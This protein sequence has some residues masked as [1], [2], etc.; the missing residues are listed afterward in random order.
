[1]AGYL[2]L[3]MVAGYYAALQFSAPSDA[4]REEASAPS[5]ITA[6]TAKAST[7]VIYQTCNDARAAGVA[8]IYKGEPGYA[9]WLD[10]DNDGVACEPYYGPVKN[11]GRKTHERRKSRY[12]ASP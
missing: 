12:A 9:P 5:G 8:P 7:S 4:L 10:V 11:F 1:M 3:A 6:S 2:G